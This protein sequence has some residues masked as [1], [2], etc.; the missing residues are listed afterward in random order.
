MW[1]IDL[2]IRPHLTYCRSRS[3]HLDFVMTCH[4]ALGAIPWNP[5][6]ITTIPNASAHSRAP[7][8]LLDPLLVLADVLYAA[9]DA[10]MKNKRFFLH[11][12]IPGGGDQH[13]R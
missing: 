12:E 4:V 11:R 3:S 6:P 8:R 1:G 7:P 10:A 2:K 5:L 13:S 9:V